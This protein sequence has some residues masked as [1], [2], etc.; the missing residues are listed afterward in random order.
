MSD[1]YYREEDIGRILA[2]LQ[3]INYQG[4][5]VLVTGGSGFLGSWMCETLLRKGAEVICLDNYASGR[6]ENTDHL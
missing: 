6:P 2:G 4:Q 5:I 3:D 1:T